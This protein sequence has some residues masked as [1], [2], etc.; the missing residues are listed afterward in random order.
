MNYVNLK[1]QR[2]SSIELRRLS[3]YAYL[4]QFCLCI[5][6]IVLYRLGKPLKPS[7]PWWPV[8]YAQIWIRLSTA[9]SISYILA[10]PHTACG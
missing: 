4:E 7:V 10:K 1:L 6:C 9:G 3:E 2:V 5:I 8:F